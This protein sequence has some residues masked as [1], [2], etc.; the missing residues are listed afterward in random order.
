MA[1]LKT[2]G[3][4]L[5][6]SG[7]TGAV[8]RARVAT[9]GTADS[10]LKASNVTRTRRAHQITAISLFTLLKRAY[11]HYCNQLDEEQIPMSLEN[12]C[13]QQAD[14]SPQFQF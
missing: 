12:W 11:I 10:F 14:A 3:N 13:A 2:L 6:G 4:L 5:D 7:W 9:T 1:A 8:V